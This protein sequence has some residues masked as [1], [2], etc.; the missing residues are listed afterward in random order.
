MS[1]RH[2]EV[3][4]HYLD[5]RVSIIVHDAQEHHGIRFGHERL[6]T[7][8]VNPLNISWH[9]TW[10]RAVTV[11]PNRLVLPADLSTDLEHPAHDTHIS[12]LTEFLGYN[13]Y[14]NFKY[15]TN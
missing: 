3:L 9:A 15:Y 7:H 10:F 14:T 12:N 11:I 4:R 13:N 8:L 6:G 5:P 2:L 1:R